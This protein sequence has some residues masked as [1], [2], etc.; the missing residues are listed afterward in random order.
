M[1]VSENIDYQQQIEEATKRAKLKKVLYL[2]D[3]FGNK[4]CLGVF[5]KKR[6]VEVKKFLRTKK[7]INR[8]SEFD[9]KTTEPDS[10]FNYSLS[11]SS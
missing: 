5:S 6:A 9:I 10:I 7:L 8:L 1:Q 3:D 4:Q 2:Y 11:T